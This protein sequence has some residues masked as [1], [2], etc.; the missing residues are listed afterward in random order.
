MGVGGFRGAI[1][2]FERLIC[3]EPIF[4]GLGSVCAWVC[5][6][7]GVPLSLEGVLGFE[8]GFSCNVVGLVVL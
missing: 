8:F 2:I 7:L 1:T 6:I 5:D 4:W 3:I